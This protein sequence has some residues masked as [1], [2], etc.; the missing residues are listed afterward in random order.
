MIASLAVVSGLLGVLS[1]TPLQTSMMLGVERPALPPGEVLADSVVASVEIEGDR[2]PRFAL[3][4][5][6]VLLTRLE[7]LVRGAPDALHVNIDPVTREGYLEQLLGETVVAREAERAG[8]ADAVSTIMDEERTRLMVRMPESAG[9]SELLSATGSSVTDFDRLVRRRALALRYLLARQ[10]RLLE[11]AEPDLHTAYEGPRFRELRESGVSFTAA[12]ARVREDLL[13][14]NL[15][16]ALRM[17]LRALGSRA[18]VRVYSRAGGDA[19]V[20]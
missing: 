2:V 7:L 12:R 15:P 17:Y 8:E 5:D 6:M 11:P 10:P 9:L 14:R 19:P 18:R 13:R 3:A 4:S 16:A 20:E 1:A